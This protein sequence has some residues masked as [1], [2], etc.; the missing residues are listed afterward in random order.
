MNLNYMYVAK[1]LNDKILVALRRVGLT[2]YNVGDEIIAVKGQ[3]V[4]DSN[5]C[6]LLQLLNKSNDWKVLDV[7]TKAMAVH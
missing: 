2:D 5:K 4:N 6:E 7:K 1:I 3:S